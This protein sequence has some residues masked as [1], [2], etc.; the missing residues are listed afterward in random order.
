MTYDFHGSWETFTGHNSPLYQGSHDTGDHI[1]FNTDFAMKYWRDQGAPVEKLMMGF[2]T[3]GRSFRLASGDSGVGAS[4]NGAASPG[5]FTREAG[6]WSYYEI[7]TFLQGAS[8]Q[9][10]DDQKVPYASKGNEWVGFD[11]RESYDTKVRYLKENGFGG[12]MVWNLDLDDFAGQTTSPATYT[13]PMV[14]GTTHSQG[15]HQGHHH[16]YPCTRWWF[17]CRQGW[18]AVCQSRF[19]ELFL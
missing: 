2:A 8:V 16:Y 11:N 6:F 19:P 18:R 10:I 1:Y 17:L 9:W 3:Y 7:C 5:P 13:H 14:R 12:A 15:H 4:A